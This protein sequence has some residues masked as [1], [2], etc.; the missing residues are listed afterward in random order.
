MDI[1]TD[2]REGYTILSLKGRLDAEGALALTPYIDRIT[3][4][5]QKV[6]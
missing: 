6:T 3:V 1:T 4:E 5:G 2:T